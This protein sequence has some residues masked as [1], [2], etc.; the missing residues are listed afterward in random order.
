[1]KPILK[2]A[3]L[4]SLMTAIYVSAVGS[5]MFYAGSIKLGQTRTA[6]LPVFMLMLLVFSAALTGALIF[7]KPVLWYME[8][9]KKEA[10]MLLAYTLGIFFAV[11]LLV[12]AGLVL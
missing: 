3:F 10:F 6:L 1:M 5:F 7:G 8:G 4:N 12:L 11:T 9:K 2:T